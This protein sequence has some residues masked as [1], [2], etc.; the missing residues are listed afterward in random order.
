MNPSGTH[1]LLPTSINRVGLGLR[2]HTPFPGYPIHNNYLSNK[3]QLSGF[4]RLD[5]LPNK[6][7]LISLA[8]CIPSSLRFFSIAL[9]L[10]MACLSSALSVHPIMINV[11]HKLNLDLGYMYLCVEHD[12]AS[13][14]Q[15]LLVFPLTWFSADV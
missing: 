15:Q 8:A 2:P 6:S 1:H 5:S 7:S 9:L 4:N 14:N 13:L 11:Y 10:S 3:P 12:V